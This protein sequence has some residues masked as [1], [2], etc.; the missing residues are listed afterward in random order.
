[1]KVSLE[2]FMPG[3]YLVYS[4]RNAAPIDPLPDAYGSI[5]IEN[6]RPAI[7]TRT[8]QPLAERARKNPSPKPCTNSRIVAYDGETRKAPA[9]AACFRLCRHVHLAIASDDWHSGNFRETRTKGEGK[10]NPDILGEISVNASIPRIFL[11]PS[12]SAYI[13][14]FFSFLFRMRRADIAECDGN[15]LFLT[16]SADYRVYGRSRDAQ[17]IIT[18]SAYICNDI[19]DIFRARLNTGE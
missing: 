4:N 9:L 18:T 2:W 3:R 10:K 8:I 7:G 6:S 5:V 15:R 13:S 16:S 11:Q 1:M 19:V 14:F 17:R 12:A